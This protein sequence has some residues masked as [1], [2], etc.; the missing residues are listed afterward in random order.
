MYLYTGDLRTLDFG[1]IEANTNPERGR[2]S[3]LP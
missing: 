1:P 2:S 3:Y